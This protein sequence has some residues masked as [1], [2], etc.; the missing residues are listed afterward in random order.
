MTKFR[1]IPLTRARNRA[2]GAHLL[3]GVAWAFVLGM[4]TNKLIDFGQ[5][6][7]ST[8]MDQV[9]EDMGIKE[10]VDNFIAKHYEQE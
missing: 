9:L 2:L 3:W 5:L 6:V 8:K 4:V 10:Q 7:E 1:K